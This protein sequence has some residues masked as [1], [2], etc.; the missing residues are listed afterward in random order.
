MAD[1]AL[2]LKDYQRMERQIEERT[3]DPT[4]SFAER[5]ALQNKL[6]NL[7]LRWQEQ[8]IG[9]LDVVRSMRD[10]ILG[11]LKEAG[12]MSLPEADFE[13]IFGEQR[14]HLSELNAIIAEAEQKG[15]SGM[16]AIKE[17]PTGPM[18]VAVPAVVPVSELTFVTLRLP[19]LQP[20]SDLVARKRAQDR[21]MTVIMKWSILCENLSMMRS[22]TLS[23]LEALEGK[24]GAVTLRIHDRAKFDS[25]QESIKQTSEQI[26]S[27]ESAIRELNEL[28][29]LSSWMI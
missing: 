13:E 5:Q 6:I 14:R 1:K 28:A 10:S 3:R 16:I 27:L 25:L 24:V 18:P 2:F 19:L 4:L 22:Q 20:Q 17:T 8:G 9:N 21:T 26:G 23:C 11:T 15:V 29:R 7:K 12:T